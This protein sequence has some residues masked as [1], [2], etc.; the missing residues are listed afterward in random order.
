MTV[1]GQDYE[2]LV[3]CRFAVKLAVNHRKYTVI[4]ASSIRL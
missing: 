3:C 4:L 1:F 2:N